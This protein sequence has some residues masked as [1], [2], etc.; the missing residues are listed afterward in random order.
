MRLLSNSDIELISGG[1][2]NRPAEMVVDYIF[3]GAV[4]GFL[5]T[6]YITSWPMLDCVAVGAMIGGAL[7]LSHAV[8]QSIDYYNYPAMV[9]VA[10]E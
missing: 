9:Q 10:V 6:F 1:Y 4:Y 2:T 3:G 5:A 7:G 8:A